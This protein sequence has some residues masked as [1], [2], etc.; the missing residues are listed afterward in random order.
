MKPTWVSTTDRL[1]PARQR[2]T[3]MLAN[4]TQIPCTCLVY[5]LK[6]PFLDVAA[7]IQ[8]QMHRGGPDLTEEQESLV[9]DF[10][11]EDPSNSEPMEWRSMANLR[12]EKGKVF[13]LEDVVYWTEITP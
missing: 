12:I 8:N 10:D 4:G 5:R 7:A 13:T 3:V 6:Q 1:P 9:K 11:F 2:T